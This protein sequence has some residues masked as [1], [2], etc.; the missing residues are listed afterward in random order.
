[1]VGQRPAPHAGLRHLALF[2]ERLEETVRF[3][4]E[5]L[6]F[7]VEWSPDPDNY[8]LCSGCDNFALHRFGGGEREP[9]QQRFDHLGL[10][11]DSADQVDA[12]HDFLAANGVRIAKAPKT[13]RDGARS[14]YCF[15]PDG[16]AV[17]IIH[18]PPVSGLRFGR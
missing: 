17:Q 2:V 10:I 4:V 6:G 11:V 16:N 18:H 5:L 8:Y 1:M 15:D 7:T 12:W 3:Y 14:F 9:A 13:H